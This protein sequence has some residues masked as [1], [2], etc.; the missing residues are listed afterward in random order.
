MRG[1]RVQLLVAAP[2]AGHAVSNDNVSACI[3]RDNA[4]CVV[5]MRRGGG[6]NRASLLGGVPERSKG[7]DCKSDGTAFEGSN[8]S[9]ST[10][11]SES[12]SE[13]G[14]WAIRTAEAVGIDRH[15]TENERIVRRVWFNGRT[16]AFQAEGAGSI[17]AT[18]SIGW[19]PSRALGRLA[20][21]DP[22][23]RKLY[24]SHSSVGRALPW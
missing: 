13:S 2:S 9:P 6:Q 14:A 16:S 17:P 20:D 18:R 1:S 21:G 8:P 10:R 15:V 24:C 7:S 23:S 5:D 22:N 12:K 19:M 4:P 11:Q 3:Y